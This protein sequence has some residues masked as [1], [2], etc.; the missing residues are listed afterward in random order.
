MARRRGMLMLSLAMILGLATAGLAWNYMQQ[1]NAQARLVAEQVQPKVDEV[2]VVVARADIP[3]RTAITAAQVELRSVPATTRHAQAVGD[4]REVVGKITKVPVSAGEQ[5]LTNKYSTQRAEAG[6]T[7]I[8]PEGKRAVAIAVSEVITSGG[9]IQPG[10]LV[11]VLAVFDA[12]KM[13]KDMATYILQGVEVLAVGQLL[14]G[15]S[16]PQTDTVQQVTTGAAVAVPGQK[17]ATPAPPKE[18]AKPQPQARSVT[19]AVTPE[20]AQRLVLAETLGKLR[21]VLRPI[22]DNSTVTLPEATL[23][24]IRVAQEPEGGVVTGVVISP[25]NARAG[26]TL[27]VQITVRNTSALPLASQGPNPEFTYV[28]GQTFQS[29]NFPSVD[30]KYRVAIGYDG[31]ASAPLP[32]RWGFGADLAPGA[33][34]TITGYIKLAHDV[35]PSNYWAALVKEPATVLQ[36]NVGTTLITVVPTNVAVIAVDVANVRSGPTVDSSVIA[37]VK[38][39]TELPIL[40]QDKDWYKVKLPDGKEGWVAAGWIVGSARSG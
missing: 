23:G 4:L 15:D 29:Q 13:G 39:G 17:V 30:G 6:L 10:D 5:V 11:D 20:E 2:Q 34:T 40:G 21:L 8:I 26:D 35:K 24:T 36:N 37:Q 33:T 7:F 25:T 27:K 19:V 18:E 38:Y 3:Y 32:Y 9:L 28:Q 16:V 1:V 22:Q 12:E 14:P 31:T